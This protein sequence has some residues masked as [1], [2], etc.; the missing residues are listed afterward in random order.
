MSESLDKIVNVISEGDLISLRRTMLLSHQYEFMFP[1][2]S[3]KMTDAP[4]SCFI[5]FFGLFSCG[6]RIT[7]PLLLIEICRSLGLCLSQLVLNSLLSYAYFC[8]ELERH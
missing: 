1:S 8:E 5:V 4:E 7:P 2:E 6:L 3:N